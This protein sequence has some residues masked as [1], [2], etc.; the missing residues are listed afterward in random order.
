MQIARLSDQALELRHDG[1][2]PIVFP[3]LWLR[4]NCPTAFDPQTKERN[5]D[6]LSVP[7]DLKP[8]SAETCDDELVITWPDGHVSRFEQ[9]WLL[10][11]QPGVPR[12]DAAALPRKIWRAADMPELPRFSGA[13]IL[14]DDRVLLDFLV[15]TQSLGLS[16]VDGLAPGQ[17]LDVAQ[18]IGFL[19]ETNFGKVF[20]VV[21]KPDPNNLAYTA[22]ALA[23]HTDLA[24]QEIPPGFQFLHC[25]ANEAQGGGSVFADS[26]AIAE[27]LRETDPG[28]FRVLSTVALPFRFHDRAYDIRLRRPVITLRPD[29]RLDEIRYNAHLTDLIDLPADQLGTFYRAYRAFMKRTRDPAFVIALRLRGGE[30]VVFDNRRTLHGRE[31][32]NPA[33]G[34]RHL[35]GCYVDR[36]EFESRIRVLDRRHDG[37]SL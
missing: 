16:L 4:D 17:G 9:S 15:T 3:F 22:Q 20:D 31:A 14:A 37:A 12:P 29:G 34:F 13:E 19:R 33:T 28:A 2:S 32:F 6:L 10:A 7:D 23:L 11:H 1:A 36:G 8:A 30:M 21:S 27:D 25:I 26:F 35:Q 24:N 5:F 18:R